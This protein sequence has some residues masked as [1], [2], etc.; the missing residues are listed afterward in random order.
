MLVLKISPKHFKRVYINGSN[1]DVN[2][3]NAFAAQFRSVNC[4]P[5]DIAVAKKELEAL[6]SRSKNDDFSKERLCELTNV[7]CVD[8]CIQNLKLGKD[9]GPD[10]LNAEH[11]QYAH[12]AIF[13]SSYICPFS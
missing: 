10:D 9:L 11:L 13:C 4:S 12:P 3:A 8:R 6:L 1:K 7:E 2:V 5:D